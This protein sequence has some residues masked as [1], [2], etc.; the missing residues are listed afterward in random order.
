MTLFPH[1][2]LKIN[3]KTYWH[4]QHN[5][6]QFNDDDPTHIKNIP[7]PVE[8][9]S[10]CRF[11]MYIW[12]RF[13]FLVCRRFAITSWCI[14]FWQYVSSIEL[15]FIEIANGVSSSIIFNKM[16][17]IRARSNTHLNWSNSMFSCDSECILLIK[18]ISCVF[19]EFWRH[20]NVTKFGFC[21]FP[22]VHREDAH[23]NAFFTNTITCWL[24]FASIEGRFYTCFGIVREITNTT[25]GVSICLMDRPTWFF[26]GI[27][28]W[29]WPSSKRLYGMIEIYIVVRQCGVFV[30]KIT[31]IGSLWLNG[32]D[33]NNLFNV[34]CWTLVCAIEGA[35][36]IS[37][38]RNII[39]VILL[40]VLLVDVSNELYVN[41]RNIQKI[42]VWHNSLK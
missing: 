37:P 16:S 33:N 11:I 36:K 20:F 4:L 31:L 22:V 21:Y 23:R 12:R 8:S 17:H 19:F 9:D 28:K 5:H 13:L 34:H 39:G 29:K 6:H 14:S 35:I 15:R 41:Y 3:T 32:I 30:K 10:K 27:S 25:L 7:I 18:F 26:L 24:I 38:E 1:H 42:R 2:S 40:S